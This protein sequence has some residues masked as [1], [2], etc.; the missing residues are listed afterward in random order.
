[1]PGREPEAT[2]APMRGCGWSETIAL[3]D[4][5]ARTGTSPPG[6]SFAVPL[7]DPFRR[8]VLPPRSPG[9][10]LPEWPHGQ[11]AQP[12]S[13]NPARRAV[14]AAEV[15]WARLPGGPTGAKLAGGVGGTRQRAQ[16]DRRS[17]LPDRHNFD[18]RREPPLSGQAHRRSSSTSLPRRGAGP[19]I[20]SAQAAAR[21]HRAPD[22]SSPRGRRGRLLRLGGLTAKKSAAN[23]RGASRTKSRAG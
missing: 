19:S 1:M 11:T 18:D 14:G 3:V 15:P 10:A 5:A 9:P 12:L 21:E 16:S 17:F 8:T 7:P 2:P 23:S 13:H 22:R 20:S 6:L 4:R